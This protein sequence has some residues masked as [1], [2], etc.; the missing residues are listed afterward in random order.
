[1]GRKIRAAKAS[2][3]AAFVAAGGA[4]AATTSARTTAA[5][6]QA[7]ATIN[8]GDPLVRFLKLDGFPAYLKIDGFT[9]YYK[10]LSTPDALQEL[11]NFYD[12]W[13]PAV[14]DVLSL[15]HKASGGSLEGILIGLEQY[16]KYDDIQPLLS[17]IKGE[18]AAQAYFKFETFL[19]YLKQD[20]PNA[21]QFFLKETSIAGDPLAQRDG[22][23]GDAIG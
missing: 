14:D 4:T 22:T 2:L 10:M 6:N 5:P 7:A 9:Q 21:F 15:Y 18:D 12:K 3:V 16:F 1:M 23:A 19:G 13:R 11:S 17:Y 8:W 20:A